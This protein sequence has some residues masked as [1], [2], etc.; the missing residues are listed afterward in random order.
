MQ[1][2]IFRGDRRA[3]ILTAIFGNEEDFNLDRY[4][5]YE[6]IEIAVPEP[7]KFSVWGNYP[8]DADLLRDTKKDLSGLLGRITDLASEVWNDDDEGAENE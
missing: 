7:G 1:R 4:A 2:L 5:I 8:D 3:D 6:E